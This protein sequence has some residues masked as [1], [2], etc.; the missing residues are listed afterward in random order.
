MADYSLAPEEQRLVAAT[1]LF[2]SLK[3]IRSVDD[4]HR[5][6]EP[7]IKQRLPP[8]EEEAFV[9]DRDKL[10][11]WL[12]TLLAGGRADVAIVTAVRQV[13][14]RTG[15]A[16]L[17]F[18]HG[19]LGIAHLELPGVEACYSFAM[20]LLM[21]RN[22][23]LTPLLRRCAAPGCDRYLLTKRGRGRPGNWCSE[24][25]RDAAERYQNAQRVKRYIDG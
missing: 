15:F 13:L 9:K 19:A 5:L 23:K 3:R 11:G 18:V 2:A 14:A 7:F 12:D 22:R 8:G 17:D 25:H 1:L 4:V 24:R 21:D 20:A 16:R 6:F 10:R